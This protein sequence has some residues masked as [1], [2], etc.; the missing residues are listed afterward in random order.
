MLVNLASEITKVQARPG[1]IVVVK[2]PAESSD[3]DAKA[4]M[5][6]FDGYLQEYPDV[7]LIVLPENCT[8]TMMDDQQLNELGLQRIPDKLAARYR[9]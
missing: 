3:E 1:D 9:R 8:I 7:F 6:A 2:I 4:V 5:D